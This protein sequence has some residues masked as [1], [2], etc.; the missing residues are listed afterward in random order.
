MQQR[1]SGT[2]IFYLSLREF[3]EL[4]NI[5]KFLFSTIFQIHSHE[6][7]NN[8]EIHANYKRK[9][10]EIANYCMMHKSALLCGFISLYP[11]VVGFGAKLK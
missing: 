10:E 6:Q 2:E 3:L 8:S 1:L 5:K 7:A 4:D 9:E 11:T